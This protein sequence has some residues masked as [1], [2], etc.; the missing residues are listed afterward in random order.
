MY[1][2]ICRDAKAHCGRWGDYNEGKGK[3]RV[4]KYSAASWSHVFLTSCLADGQGKK[5]YLEI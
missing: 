2:F 5:N 4:V 1:S 3:K